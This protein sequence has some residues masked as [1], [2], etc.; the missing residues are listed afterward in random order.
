MLHML[1]VLPAD[2]STALKKEEL[3]SFGAGVS[4]VSAFIGV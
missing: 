2:I 4:P 1:Q 3:L